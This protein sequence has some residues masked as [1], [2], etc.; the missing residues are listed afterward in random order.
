LFKRKV[1]IHSSDKILIKLGRTIECDEKVE[2]G[3]RLCLSASE[4]R[5]YIVAVA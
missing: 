2:K 4:K 5:K 1:Y 3:L